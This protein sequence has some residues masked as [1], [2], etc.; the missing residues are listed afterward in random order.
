[1]L[2]A[3]PSTSLDI[4]PKL[5]LLLLAV[6]LFAAFGKALEARART[7]RREARKQRQREYR[8]YLRSDGWK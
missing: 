5:I 6:G 7:R 8:H 1:M 2:F 4:P 3:Q